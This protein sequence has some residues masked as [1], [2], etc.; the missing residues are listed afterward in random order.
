MKI[1]HR[2]ITAAS[3]NK[4]A[5]F[6][7]F[8][9]K[10]ANASSNVEKVSETDDCISYVVSSDDDDDKED[11]ECKTLV[12]YKGFKLMPDEYGGGWNVF[13]QNSDLIQNHLFTEQDAKDY[14]D[15][16]VGGIASSTVPSEHAGNSS[17]QSIS[18]A[19]FDAMSNDII[20]RHSDDVNPPEYEE[21]EAEQ[22]TSIF[23]FDVTVEVQP[24]T[25][26]SIVEG[27]PLYHA[28]IL[29]ENGITE[30]E[31]YDDFVFMLGSSVPAESG[32]YI[33]KGTAKLVYEKAPLDDFFLLE[34]S[35]SSIRNLT[36][37]RD[38]NV[39]SATDV[40]SAENITAALTEGELD[41]AIEN[42]KA[43]DL[44][45]FTEYKNLDDFGAVIAKDVQVGDVI[46]IDSAEEVNLG[47]V[48]KILSIN[49][50]DLM[51]SWSDF[52]FHCEIVNNDDTTTSSEGDLVDLHFLA[53]EP[54]GYLLQSGI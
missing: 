3:A 48:V 43:F 52:V 12:R 35:L 14:V 24:N 20:N 30:E 50:P 22:A 39:E 33:L 7:G 28:D 38:G 18:G 13:N 5:G 9:K 17:T 32:K 34:P 45:S 2:K 54:V 53:D 23:A 25:D 40:Y 4:K 29:D 16:Y 26:W 19:S 27:D 51:V 41:N 6:V 42:N 21:A 1:S 11:I 47:T 44:A 10:K 37:I 46:E 49:D 36:V 8:D 31:M 15:E